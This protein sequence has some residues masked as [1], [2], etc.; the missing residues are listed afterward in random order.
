[1]PSTRNVPSEPVVVF[2]TDVAPELLEVL[3]LG[4]LSPGSR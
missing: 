4:A 3:G 2:T 1:L